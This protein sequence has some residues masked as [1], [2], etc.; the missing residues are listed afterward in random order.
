MKKTMSLIL[1]VLFVFALFAGCSGGGGS[2]TTP[3]QPAASGTPEA[4]P[5]AT[6]D[7]GTTTT[8]SATTDNL[9]AGKYDVDENG[10]PTAPYDYTAPLTTSDE[11]FTFW[12]VV[13][14]TAAIP[15]DGYGA[16]PLPVA[17]HEATGVNIEYVVISQDTRQQNYSVL[18]AADDL[19]DISAQATAYHP[20][21]AEQAIED[22]YWVNIYDYMEYCPNY[23]YQ[24]TYNREEDE[25]TYHG[26]F[27]RSDIIAAFYNINKEPFVASNY[28]ARG[29]WLAELGLTNDDIVTYDDLHDMLVGFKTNIGTCTFPWPIFNTLDMAGNAT[30]LAFDTVPSVSPYAVGPVYVVDGEVKLAHMN[31]GDLAFMTMLNQWYS[32]GLIHPDWASYDN[33]TK[34]TDLIISDQVGYVYMSPGEVSS[35]ETQSSDPDVEWV[36]IHRP[37]LEE[38]QVLHVGGQMTRVSYGSASISADCSNIPLIVSWCDWRYSPTGSD[39]ASWGPE[40][41]LWEYDENGVRRATDFAV[42]NPYGVGY[43][44]CCLFYGFNSLAEHGMEDTD[45]KYA[46]E[47]GERLL[48]MH[49]YW[50]DCEYDG[51]YDWPAGIK[52]TQEQTDVINEYSNDAITFLSENYLAFVDSSKPLSEWDSYVSGLLDLG[53]DNI[54]AVYQEAYDDYMATQN[55]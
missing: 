50:G 45:R 35:Y 11:V 4:T 5:D 15:E 3:T 36:P 7:P 12:T 19:C 37:L 30:F 13:W 40:G 10:Y 16:S 44:W 29:D 24:A 33:N 17:E 23:I 22:G 39:L 54:I 25:N 18:L 9:P 27:Y 52:L 2:T 26:I 51:A 6:T 32:E 34:F 1:A 28:M 47:G 55:A 21:T 48:A 53:M 8:P 14:S 42:N 49:D 43:A 20:T 46:V 41:V 38:G 31:E